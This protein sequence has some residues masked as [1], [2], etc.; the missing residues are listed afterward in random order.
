MLPQPANL[1]G[2]TPDRLRTLADQLQLIAQAPGGRALVATMLGMFGPPGDMAVRSDPDVVARALHE[3]ATTDLGPRLAAIVA[4]L[5]VLYAIPDPLRRA[6]LD[7][8]Y[9]A[10][11]RAVAGV[12]LVPIDRSGHMIMADQPGRFTTELRAFLRP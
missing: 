2:S 10:A 1:V 4:P 9:A 12:R 3:L 5:T 8:T 7:R 11:Y 6:S